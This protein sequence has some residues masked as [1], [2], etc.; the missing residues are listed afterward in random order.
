MGCQYLLNEVL[1]L[2]M[3]A[4]GSQTERVGYRPSVTSL[5]GS[6][7]G[8][9]TLKVKLWST[10]S[11]LIGICIFQVGERLV[12]ADRHT[13]GVIVGLVNYSACAPTPFSMDFVMNDVSTTGLY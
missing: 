7:L 2:I 4:W 1:S 3:T 10:K 5:W 12:V 11:I 9:T 6:L 8:M 13:V